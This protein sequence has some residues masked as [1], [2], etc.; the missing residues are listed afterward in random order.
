[1]AS[2]QHR[3]EKM[4]A[5]TRAGKRVLVNVGGAPLYVFSSVLW[6]GVSPNVQLT[7]LDG[8]QRFSK[9]AAE[10]RKLGVDL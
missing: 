7:S 5:R 8:T 3:L 4:L 2:Q 10:W 1:M 6:G 9:T